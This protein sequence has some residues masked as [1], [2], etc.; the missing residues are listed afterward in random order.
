[1]PELQP[2]AIILN[3]YQVER[4]LGKGAFGEVYLAQHIKLKVPRA[5]KIL[6]HDAMGVGSTLY[7]DAHERFEQDAQLG[8][9]L[10]QE[11]LNEHII[12]VFDYQEENDVERLMLVMEY[13]AG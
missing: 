10:E 6:R 13:A 7:R 2:N 11:H 12:K 4:L 1:M 9:M 3:T 5:L 8:A